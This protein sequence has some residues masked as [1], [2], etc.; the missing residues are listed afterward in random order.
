MTARM[1]TAV[2]QE[3][4]I[5]AAL[6]I[7]AGQGVSAITVKGVARSVGVSPSALYRHFKSKEDILLG[8]QDFVGEVIR[9]SLQR[10][11]AEPRALDGVR[12]L[13]FSVIKH[14]NDDRLQPAFFLSAENWSPDCENGQRMRM[15]LH[16]VKRDLTALFRKAQAQ[17][18]VRAELDPAQLAIAFTG[19]YIP[20]ALFSQRAPEIVDFEAQVRFNWELF[21]RAVST[22]H[23][24]GTA[25]QERGGAELQTP[26]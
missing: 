19:L 4:I 9:S 15:N 7:A 11:L 2:R 13:L 24:G 6:E 17:E 25:P 22:E 23:R 14:M 26:G 12:S 18:D 3:Q 1:E 8:M 5:R 16:M 21:L 20:G 10:A